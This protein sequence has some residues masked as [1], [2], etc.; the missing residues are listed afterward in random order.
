ML[1]GKKFYF[2][3]YGLTTVNKIVKQDHG[4][5]S[6]YLLLKWEHMPYICT[7]IEG[8][9]FLLAHIFISPLFQKV[10]FPG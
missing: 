10:K 1:Q 2:Q 8:G 9:N 6:I 4:K 3:V 7:Y 5:P